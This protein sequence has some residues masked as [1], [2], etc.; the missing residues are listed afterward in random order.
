[1]PPILPCLPSTCSPAGAAQ[2]VQP[3]PLDTQ[4]E[5]DRRTVPPTCGQRCVRIPYCAL[6]PLQP[7]SQGLRVPLGPPSYRILDTEPLS[8]PCRAPTTPRPPSH[9]QTHITTPSQQPYVPYYSPDATLAHYRQKY[10]PIALDT[11]SEPVPAP[12]ADHRP[13]LPVQSEST[14]SHP[15]LQASPLP[16]T[17]HEHKNHRVLQ[18]GAS[19]AVYLQRCTRPVRGTHTSLLHHTHHTPHTSHQLRAKCP[20]HESALPVRHG[21]PSPQ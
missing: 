9:M 1:M 19:S 18:A 4:R 8:T 7:F 3:G 10:A 20:P 14:I 6:R 17:H 21:T 5:P 13:L 15:L 12:P 16:P 2:R 11:P